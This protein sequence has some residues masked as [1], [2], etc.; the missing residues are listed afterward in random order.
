M[1]N[2]YVYILDTLADWELGYVIA[3]LNSGRYFR[4]KGTRVPVKTVGLTHDSVLTQGGIRLRPD[5]TVDAIT[6]EST[7]VLLLPGADTWLE[8]QHAPLIEKTK[9][10]LDSG[11]TVGAI[12]GATVALACAGCLNNR[13]HTS[14]SLDYLKMTCPQYQGEA[15]YQDDKSVTDGNLITASS[16]GGLLFARNILA[17]LDVFSEA[18]LTAW[19]HYFQTGDVQSF[20]TMM[21]TLPK[22]PASM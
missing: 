10:L 1:N 13:P 16:A 11:T 18:T 19:Y 17:R 12:C 6:P 20:Q 21:Q 8:P 2:A 3:E 22:Q 14:N 15:F 5:T 9:E 4:Q 7:A